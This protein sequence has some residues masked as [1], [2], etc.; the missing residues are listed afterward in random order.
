VKVGAQSNEDM[1]QCKSCQ[2]LP[3]SMF[4]RIPKKAINT[5]TRLQQKAKKIAL[6]LL[7]P[8]FFI[9]EQCPRYV[10]DSYQPHTSPTLHVM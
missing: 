2:D 9:S 6:V 5:Q 4:L 10:E 1:L 8:I 7:S 3:V